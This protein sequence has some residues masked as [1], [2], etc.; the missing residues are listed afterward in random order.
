MTCW[1]RSNECQFNKNTDAG[2]V[3]ETGDLTGCVYFFCFPF[4]SLLEGMGTSLW[5]QLSE[6]CSVLGVSASPG[7]AARHLLLCRLLSP[8]ESCPRGLRL[9]C[10][11]FS[12]LSAFCIARLLFEIPVWF[13]MIFFGEMS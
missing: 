3:V 8:G 1:V 4:S 9:G 5:Q 6:L 7:D 13:L 12:G 10:F 2:V 11:W